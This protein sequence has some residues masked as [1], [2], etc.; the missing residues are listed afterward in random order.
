MNPIGPATTDK[1]N[2]E[3]TKGFKLLLLRLI[4]TV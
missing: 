4:L 3:V 1:M 2:L